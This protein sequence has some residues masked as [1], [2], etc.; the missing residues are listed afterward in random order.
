[1]SQTD[2]DQEKRAPEA[3]PSSLPLSL[4]GRPPVVRVLAVLL[5]SWLVAAAAWV[6]VPMI[7]VPMTMQSFAIVAIGA[8]AGWR[9]GLATMLAYLAQGAAGLPVFAGGTSGLAVFSGPTA[10]YLLGF[11]LA[12]ALCGLLAE[13]GWNRRLPLLFGSLLGGHGVI[14]LVGAAWLARMIG[15]A[16]AVA[17]GLIP[18]LAGTVLKSALA[19]ATVTAV[20]RSRRA[21]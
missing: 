11:P 9:L 6:E 2:P 19:T 20:L 10:G 21:A 7:P 14:L 13:R 16:D 17:L 12:A 15:P 5:G 1:M 3:M 4:D 8:L 18:F